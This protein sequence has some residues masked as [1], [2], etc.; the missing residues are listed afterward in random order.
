MMNQQAMDSLYSATYMEDYLDCVE[1]L[2]DDIQRNMS[3]MRDLDI[4]YSSKIPK[5]EKLNR[6]M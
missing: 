3:R 6:F 5:N 1:N 4:Q 2:P